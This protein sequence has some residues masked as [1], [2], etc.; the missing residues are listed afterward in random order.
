M[1]TKIEAIEDKILVKVIKPERKSKGG[2]VIPEVA[3]DLPQS[4]GKVL[5]VGESV[6]QLIKVESTIVFHQR[7][8]MDILH[9]DETLKILK[10]DEV[11]G[12]LTV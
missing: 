5:S 8:G 12:V 3:G 2:I 7:A 9:D 1:E 6:N 10:N 11:Y 4:Y